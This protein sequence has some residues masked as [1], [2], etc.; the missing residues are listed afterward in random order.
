MDIR[1]FLKHIKAGL[2]LPPQL[3]DDGDFANNT[4]FDCQG[5]G[6]VLVLFIV[7]ALDIA[8]GSTDEAT[9]PALEECD[10]FG[11]S[12]TAITG[13]TLSAVIGASDDNKL[14]GIF[15][16]RSVGA[17]KRYLKVTTPHAGDG[18]TG[19]N[20]TI[21][22]LGFPADNIPNSSAEMGLEELVSV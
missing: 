22:A 1:S 17:R 20:L 2:M 6:A 15:V 8:V 12:Y 14:Y 18:T 10:T 11:G 3:K 16:D 21:L 13:A 5:I 9:P 4:Y 19:A 7:G